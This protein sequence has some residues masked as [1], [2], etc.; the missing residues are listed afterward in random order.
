MS[1]SEPPSRSC[2]ARPTYTSGTGP[3]VC[4]VCGSP[5]TGSRIISRLP[6]S[7]VTIISPPTSSSAARTAPSATS[8]ACAASIAADSDAGVADH[9]RV[10]DIA[11]DHVVPPRADVL[12][13]ARGQLRTAHLR[14]QVVGGDLRRRHQHAVL[15]RLRRFPA[16]AEEERHVRV[17]FGFGDAQLGQAVGGQHF[18]QRVVQIVGAEGHRRRQRDVVLAQADEARQLAVGA[19]W[20]NRRSPAPRSTRSARARGR[21][22]NS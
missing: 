11:D 22:G 17:L 7:A 19:A 14:L 5:V 2:A 8:T 9:V 6:W 1:R 13:Q 10:G 21:R 4:A 12:A 15:A 20:R 16:A 3:T 18:R